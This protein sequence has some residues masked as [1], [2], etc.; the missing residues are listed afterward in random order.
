MY[1]YVTKKNNTFYQYSA[2]Y[3]NKEDA[4]KW[5]QDYGKELAAMFDRKIKLIKRNKRKKLN[6]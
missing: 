4:E 5:Y 3:E 1:V 2:E 6:K